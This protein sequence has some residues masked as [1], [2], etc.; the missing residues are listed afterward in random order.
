MTAYDQLVKE[1][2]PR[3]SVNPRFICAHP[4]QVK[5]LYLNKA[6]AGLNPYC[7]TYAIAIEHQHFINKFIERAG[8]VAPQAGVVENGRDAL[9]HRLIASRLFDDAPNQRMVITGHELLHAFFPSSSALN[10][11]ER[12]SLSVNDGTRAVIP[13][14][15]EVYAKTSKEATRKI[16]AI[17]DR[18]YL[19]IRG[20][21]P[22]AFVTPVSTASHAALPQYL[23]CNYHCIGFMS[24]D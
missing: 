14:A 20:L 4:D 22:Y 5:P 2:Y 17:M 12:R 16:K 9:Y 21:D 23:K 6:R 19:V 1:V 18:A 7:M 13:V 10:K 3:M 15:V 24:N 8:D 11:F